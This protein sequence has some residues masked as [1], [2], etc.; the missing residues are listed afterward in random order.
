M[1]DLDSYHDAVLGNNNI[2]R[3]ESHCLNYRMILLNVFGGTVVVVIF[4]G[5]EHDGDN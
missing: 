2:N 5:F 3:N 1:P 4:K